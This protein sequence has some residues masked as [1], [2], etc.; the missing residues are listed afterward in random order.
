MFRTAIV[1]PAAVALAVTGLFVVCGACGDSPAAP[2]PPPSS[3]IPPSVPII[4]EVRLD[5]PEMVPLGEVVQ[6]KL[7]ALDGSGSYLDVTNQAEWPPAE[8]NVVS[9][10]APGRVRG[11]ERG[12]TSFRATF[13]QR[14][15]W[16]F[17]VVL[18]RGTHRLTGRVREADGSAVVADALVEVTQG[19]GDGLSALTDRWGQYALFGVSGQTHLRVSKSGYRTATDNLVV[20]D[21]VTHDLR[22]ALAGSRPNVAGAYTLTLGPAPECGRGLGV[23]RLPDDLGA[24]TYA[25]TVSQSGAALTV[26]V[27]AGAA[28][29]IQFGGTVEPERVTFFIDGPSHSE[30]EPV[31]Q[32]PISSSRTLVVIGGVAAPISSTRLAGPFS[33]SLRVFEDHREIASCTSTAHEFAMSR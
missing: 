8:D 17:V 12:Q 22:L 31:F 33:G 29:P 19:V 25:A 2:T 5:G 13:Q 32:V 10:E 24:P 27:D 9:I 28:L 16:K 18:P 6:Y 14:N 23:Q 4:A 30:E 11:L 26:S 20:M 15:A 7:I 21:S 1:K 3:V